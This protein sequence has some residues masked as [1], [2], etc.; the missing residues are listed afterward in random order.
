MRFFLLSAVVLALLGCPKSKPETPAKPHVLTTIAPLARILR[1]VAGNRILVG[2]L[3]PPGASPHTYELRPSDFR[4]AESA[5]AIF[6][7][8]KNLDGWATKLPA[9][10]MIEVFPLLP[11]EF[12][13]TMP[14]H[15][16]SGEAEEATHEAGDDPH[17]WCDPLAVQALLP[18]LIDSLS[19]LDPEGR[20]TFEANARDFSVR[21]EKLDADLRE[22]FAPM[23][24]VSLALFHPSFLYFLRRYELK[25]AGSIEPF[26]GKEPSA[27]YI[28][29][30]SAR[31]KSSGAKAI[32][33]EP[34]FPSQPAEILAEAAG[35][36]LGIINPE[37]SAEPGASY[38]ELLLANAKM[39]FDAIK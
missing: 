19:E 7:V 16:H 15:S 10:K 37:G 38:E 34:Q 28:A 11:K 2:V 24:G 18:A 1:E 31:L 26:P 12:R 23:R 14:D 5:L 17:F 27:K 20:E 13:G 29:E 22:M 30:M 32:F 3:L 21:I 25:Y 4:N 36:R 6:W 8:H 39:I 33:T 35:L 9:K